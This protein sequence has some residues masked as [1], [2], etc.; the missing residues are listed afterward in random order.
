MQ[1]AAKNNQRAE[2]GY[3][4]PSRRNDESQVA[5]NEIGQTAL[6]SCELFK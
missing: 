4:Q 5:S 6:I 2:Y 1:R 3:E